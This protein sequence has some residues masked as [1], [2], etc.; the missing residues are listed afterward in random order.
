MDR[1]EINLQ[2]LQRRLVSEVDW[3]NNFGMQWD[4]LYVDDKKTKWFRNQEQDVLAIPSI[5]DAE[6]AQKLNENLTQLIF[7]FGLGSIDELLEI[8]KLV[9]KD[10]FFVIVEP[11]LSI[12]KSVV[13][14][15][16]LQRLEHLKYSIIAGPI[17]NFEV[18]F[19]N[20]ISTPILLLLKRPVF[21][22]NSYYRNHELAVVRE[23]IVI[24]R[25]VIR[26]KMFRIG[27]DI[28]DSLVGLINNMKNLQHLIKTPDLASLKNKFSGLPIFVVAAGPSLDKNMH[29]L[30]RVGSSGIIVAVDTIAEKLVD[31]GIIPHFIASVERFNVWEY[32]YRDKPAFYKD[33][34]LLAPLLVQ[35][36]VLAL[37]GA[38][39]V[40]PMRQS[41]REYDWLREMLEMGHE[42]SIWMGGSCAHIAAGFA[43]HLGGAP[44]VLVGQDLAYG[45]DITKTHANGTEYDDKPEETPEEIYTVEGYYGTPVKTQ[46]IWN[47][48]R[49]LYED[50]FR[51]QNVWVI[52]ATEGGAKI[53]GTEQATLASV[54]DKY[55]VKAC[56]INETL[57]MSPKTRVDFNA[58]S[59]KMRAYCN[60]LEKLSRESLRHLK[61]LQEIEADWELS[62]KKKG[63]EGIFRLMQKTDRYFVLMKQD[64]LVHHNLQGPALILLQKFHTIAADDSEAS[65][66][67]N[68]SLQI[69]FCEMYTNTLWII[70]RLIKENYPWREAEKC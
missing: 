20:I 65:L 47:N 59:K 24:L 10:S 8:S 26:D 22:L 33:S 7:F 23:H 14:N 13:A 56:D 30:K 60:Q 25:S 58:V 19:K 52:N 12:L 15:D 62:K 29:E 70:A 17:E 3:Q 37:Y 57:R 27:N 11:N 21:Y 67:N 5:I 34:Y 2:I 43:I 49:S 64:K 46:E 66:K 48:F 31:N 9:H 51:S 41:T 44:V 1:K 16:D 42:Y 32:F 18:S 39:A 40:L 55:C 6:F 63:L 4:F 68:L 69:E 36:E 53:Q 45:D 50:A 38:N 54:V 35:P 28:L 61:K